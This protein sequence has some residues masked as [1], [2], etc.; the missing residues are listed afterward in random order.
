MTTPQPLNCRSCR[1]PLSRI[2][3]DLGLSPIANAFP[4]ADQP[5][6]ESIYPLRAF[7]CDACLLVQVEPIESRESHFHADYAYFSSYSQSWLAHARR[8]AEMAIDR[9]RLTPASRVVEIGSND[10]YLLRHF[11]GRGIPVLGIDPAEKAAA[12]AGAHGVETHVGFFGRDLGRALAGKGLSA[13][14]IVANNVL[15]HVPDLDDFLGGFSALLKPAG[16]ITFEFPHLLKLIELTEFDTIYHEH[17]SYLSL[18][19][20]RRLFPRHDLAPIDVERLPTHGG[21]LRLFVGKASAAR[22][23]SAALAALVAEERAAGLH[24]PATYAA[25]DARVRARKRALLRLLIELKESGARLCGYGAPA[26]ATTLLNYCGIGTDFIDFTVD[27]NPAKQGRLV[28]GT[29]IPILAPAALAAARPDYVLILP[30]NLAEEIIGDLAYVR[31]WGGRFILP[32]P[33][34]RIV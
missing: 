12:A 6:P 23:E 28:P 8:Y 17:Y 15:A 31:D 3:A 7:V 26:K 20:L 1:A 29:R 30:W 33:E 25:F 16:T 27:R 18:V 22:G 14:L 11:V 32:I 10:G 34:P 4:S 21:S 9:F 19:A 5:S 13:D 2:F 24:D